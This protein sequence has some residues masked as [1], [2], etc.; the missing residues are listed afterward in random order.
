MFSGVAAAAV[1]LVISM[2]VKMAEPLLQERNYL[3]HAIAVAAFIAVGVLRW[4]IWWVMLVL[5]P[6]SIAIAWWG[7]R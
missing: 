2:T 6:A 1:G 3:V 7:R 5:I 4:P